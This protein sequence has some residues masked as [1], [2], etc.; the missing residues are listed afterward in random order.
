M[1]DAQDNHKSKLQKGRQLFSAVFCHPQKTQCLTPLEKWR[2]AFYPEMEALKETH[3]H[4]V[5]NSNVYGQIWL[6]LCLHVTATESCSCA[7]NP[8]IV[9]AQKKKKKKK[10]VMNSCL[11]N[12][13]VKVGW[14]TGTE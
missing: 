7:L 2:E 12:V 14:E 8:E 11:S 4:V 6:D 3:A 10:S 1:N 5:G 9:S 13:V